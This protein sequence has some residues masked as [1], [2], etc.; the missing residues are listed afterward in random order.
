MHIQLYIIL[1]L[2]GL[3]GA[4]DVKCCG[5]SKSLQLSRLGLRRECDREVNTAQLKAEVQALTL[6]R[7]EGT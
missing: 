4:I 6:V 2:S 7:I 1:S 5:I 3:E